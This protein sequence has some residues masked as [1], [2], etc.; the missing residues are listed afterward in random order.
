[1][2]SGA[3][4]TTRA[5][6]TWGATARNTPRMSSA[7]APAFERHRDLAPVGGRGCVESDQRRDPDQGDG[8]GGQGRSLPALP[9]ADGRCDRVRL[10]P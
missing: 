1:M 5:V 9:Q 4:A 2:S 8:R 6:P 3:A 7:L 10:A